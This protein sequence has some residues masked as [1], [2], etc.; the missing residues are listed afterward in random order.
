[1]KIKNQKKEKNLDFSIRE[2][3][4]CGTCKWSQTYFNILSQQD[5]LKCIR[6]DKEIFVSTTCVCDLWDT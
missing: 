2:A 5:G 6:G 1:M 3:K 4:C